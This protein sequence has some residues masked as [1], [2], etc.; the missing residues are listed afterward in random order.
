MICVGIFELEEVLWTPMM[1]AVKLSK[2]VLQSCILRSCRF[3]DEG[4][5]TKE[6]INMKASCCAAKSVVTSFMKKYVL[7]TSSSQLA[8]G[9]AW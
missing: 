4:L 9:S 3:T 2:Q 8:G 7:A 5:Q 6:Q 1:R